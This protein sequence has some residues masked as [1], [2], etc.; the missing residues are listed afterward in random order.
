MTIIEA[1]LEKTKALRGHRP[2][3]LNPPGG[4]QHEYS[5]RAADR[6]PAD[7]AND[8][9]PSHVAPSSQIKPH[10]VAFDPEAARENRLLL[11]ASLPEDR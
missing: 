4:I 11:S 5:R 10:R 8:T 2:E 1:A 3:P 9:I 6:T 7:R